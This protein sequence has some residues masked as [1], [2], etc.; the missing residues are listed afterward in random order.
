MP[1][2]NLLNYTTSIE[3][4]KTVGEIQNILVAHG[5]RV[6]L[7]E[8]AQDGTI[9]ALSFRIN[10]PHGELAVRLPVK[11]DAILEILKK[12]YHSGRVPRRYIDRPQAVRIAWRITKDWIEAQCAIIETEMVSID[13]VFLPYIIANNGQTLYHLLQERNFLLTE[14]KQ[15]A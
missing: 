9:D 4:I 15:S 10:S 6:I 2:Q 1:R 5:A 13:E 3:A 8:Y 14:G 12:Q 7:M 11:P